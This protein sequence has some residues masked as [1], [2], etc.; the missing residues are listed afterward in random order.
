VSL[1]QTTTAQRPVPAENR[2][3][4]R[5]APRNGAFIIVLVAVIVLQARRRRRRREE[6]ALRDTLPPPPSV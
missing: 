4:E 6:E 3:I 1:A 5:T 2:P